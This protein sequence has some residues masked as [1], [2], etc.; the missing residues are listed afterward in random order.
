V[1]TSVGFNNLTVAE[2]TP[3]SFRALRQQMRRFANDQGNIANVISDAA[4]V[5]IE[6]E[7]RMMEIQ[8]SPGDP[9]N[10]RRTMNPEANTADIIVPLYMTSTQ[11]W[12]IVNKAMMKENLVWFD[13]TKPDF[14]QVIDFDTFQLKVSG[15][16][17]W[18]WMCFGWRWVA[19]ASVA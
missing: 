13:H 7:Q 16:G 6:L 15:Y 5:P 2:L 1:N 14:K 12:G 9:D 11:N 10:A 18:S 19:W 3:V 8:M 17:R 4:V